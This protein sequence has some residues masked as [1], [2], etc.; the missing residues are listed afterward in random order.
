MPTLIYHNEQSY[1]YFISKSSHFYILILTR[2]LKKWVYHEPKIK[3]SDLQF[4]MSHHVCLSK[5]VLIF[6]YFKLLFKIFQNPNGLTEIIF[7]FLWETNWN[8]TWVFTTANKCALPRAKT[9]HSTEA[10]E[11]N[12]VQN[13]ILTGCK[14][15]HI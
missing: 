8:W 9:M 6:K 4:K 14:T 13:I 5:S 3:M 11:I 10:N 15:F 2:E 7:W 12:V 1:I